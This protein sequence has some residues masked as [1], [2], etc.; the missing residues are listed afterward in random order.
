MSSFR[1]SPTIRSIKELRKQEAWY[2]D[3]APT[4]LAIWPAVVPVVEARI[5]VLAP[6]A[7]PFG[8]TA[9]QGVTRLSPVVTKHY[10]S[11][12]IPSRQFWRLRPSLIGLD[13]MDML[14]PMS[15][16][17]RVVVRTAPS[18]PVARSSPFERIATFIQTE[19]E[20][21]TDIVLTWIYKSNRFKWIDRRAMV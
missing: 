21:G 20:R 14:L 7:K 10:H 16:T 1:N 5:A 4:L 2:P 6:E 15:S 8:C 18:A 12:I 11:R 9:W 19:R 17:A 13:D 3:T